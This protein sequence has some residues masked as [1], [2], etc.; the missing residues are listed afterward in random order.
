[1][2]P[3]S[4]SGISLWMTPRPAVIH[5]TP[6]PRDQA[7]VAGRI[8]VAHAP[9]EHVA[10][11]FEAAVR[12]VGEAADVVA[13]VVGTEGVEHQEGVEPALQVLREHAGELDA[14]TVAGGLA[15]DQA[16]DATRPRQGGGGS[17]GV[18]AA[19]VARPRGRRMQRG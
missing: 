4:C 17:G 16:L 10:H 14:G 3:A 15:G 9:V 5:C 7:L 12:M 8:A 18:H 11:G 2:R 1:M 6:P 13:R 19:M